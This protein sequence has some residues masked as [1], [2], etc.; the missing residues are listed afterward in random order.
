MNRGL[1]LTL[2]LI[3]ILA[4]TV[5]HGLAFIGG[6]KDSYYG[7]GSRGIPHSRSYRHRPHAPNDGHW[8]MKFHRGR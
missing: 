8:H 2:G 5:Q 3:T 4:S 7:S 1:M 6:G